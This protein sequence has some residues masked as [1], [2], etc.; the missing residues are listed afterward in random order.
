MTTRWPPSRATERVKSF[1]RIKSI[2]ALVSGCTFTSRWDALPKG[3]KNKQMNFLQDATIL[4][5]HT[6]PQL[7][8]EICVQI[9]V[10]GIGLSL[11]GN[12]LLL[13]SHFQS[14]WVDGGN[15]YNPSL[16]D[17]LQIDINQL[18]QGWMIQFP[19]IFKIKSTYFICNNVKTIKVKLSVVPGLTWII[20]TVDALVIVNYNYL[21]KLAKTKCW[22]CWNSP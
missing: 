10:M 4:S 19:P 18:K 22:I 17:Q 2:I 14:V 8:K 1:S 21:C 12:A 13:D 5:T 7:T 16:I 15:N 11:E 9:L 3:K 20:H 6:Q